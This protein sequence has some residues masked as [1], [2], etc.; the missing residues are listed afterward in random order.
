MNT[1]AR[2]SASGGPSTIK[3]LGGIWRLY[4]SDHRLPTRSRDSE[5]TGCQ[6]RK[7]SAFIDIPLHEWMERPLFTSRWFDSFS[8]R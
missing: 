4:R 8:R 3:P 2:K 1:I 5:I 7:V 6:D